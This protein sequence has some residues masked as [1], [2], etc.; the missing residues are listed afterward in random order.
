MFG[1]K[2]AQQLAV[3]RRMTA[4][5]SFPVEIVGAPTVRSIDGLAVSSRNVFLSDAERATALGLSSGLFAAAKAVTGGERAAATLESVVATQVV[6][7]GGEVEYVTLADAQEAESIDMLDRAAFLA[8]AARVGD[9]RLIDNV[10]LW[11]DGSS[12]T[13][14]RLDQ[15]SLLRRT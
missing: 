11:P 15:P 9:V 6:A 4:D 10:I 12:D 2:D 3:V 1:R 14:I 5:L 7:T 8:V 13:G